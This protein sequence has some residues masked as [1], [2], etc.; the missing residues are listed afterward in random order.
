MTYDPL[1]QGLGPTAV[2]S[3]AAALHL[4]TAGNGLA[5][6]SA[7]PDAA[8]TNGATPMDSS[9]NSGLPQSAPAAIPAA[10]VP[11][12]ASVPVAMP[13]GAIAPQPPKAHYRCN[14]ASCAFIRAA[15]TRC[16]I[17]SC[18]PTVIA[19]QWRFLFIAM[20]IE[21]MVHLASAAASVLSLPPVILAFV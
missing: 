19:F 2:M 16:A 4:S 5:Q 3:D 14:T 8:H 7:A 9:L 6:Q 20:G 18:S 17:Q 13:Q 12:A 15:L 1:A 10:Q 21:H 11:A